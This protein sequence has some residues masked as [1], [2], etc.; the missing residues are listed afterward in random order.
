M[1]TITPIYAGVLALLFVVLSLRVIAGRRKF[2]VGFGDGGYDLLLRRIRVHSNFAEHVP[3]VILL[4]ILAENQNS[5]DWRIHFI[6]IVLIVGRII[7]AFGV[8]RDPE[9]TGS[10]TLGM[11]MTFT[12]MIFA[13][14][15]NL[16]LALL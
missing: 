14:T 8:G 5:P 9:I 7:H 16:S 3:L 2:H 11:A 10:R 1:L 4:M 15:T 6:G 12:A 13:A